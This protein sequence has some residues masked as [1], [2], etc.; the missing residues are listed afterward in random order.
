MMPAW[1]PHIVRVDGTWEQTL[2]R[3][4]HIFEIDF[5]QSHPSFENKQVIWD[6]R[7]LDDLFDEGFWHL[8]T[9]KDGV[10][11]ERLPD[12]PRA[13]R[14]PWCAPTINHSR[15][16]IV[17]NWDY[18]E[19]SGRIRSYLWL[20]D[21]DYIVILEKR[22]QRRGVVAFLVT[23]YHVDGASTRRNLERKFN[24]RIP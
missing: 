7:K 21:W 8:I 22:N 3:L 9:R 6:D 19:A 15:D 24:N 10:T 2:V 18:E 20:V 13:E 14:L 1:L 23:A 17:R 11:G 12:F 5:V 4:Y 16:P